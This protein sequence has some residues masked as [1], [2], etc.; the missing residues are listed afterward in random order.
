M[1]PRYRVTLTELERNEK[2]I[3]AGA[4]FLCVDGI[5]H[6]G[7]AN[8]KKNEFKAHLGKYW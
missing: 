6:D 3:H 5:A 1:S 2:F 7:A 8:Y 4:L